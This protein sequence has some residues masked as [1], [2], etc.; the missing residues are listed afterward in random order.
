MSLC[1]FTGYC[2]CQLGPYWQKGHF[3][4]IVSMDPYCR[5]SLPS[6]HP[7]TTL[8]TISL[9]NPNPKPKSYPNLKL[10]NKEAPIHTTQYIRQLNE[11]ADLSVCAILTV[12]FMLFT[13]VT[14][15]RTDHISRTGPTYRSFLCK[16][17]W[18]SRSSHVVMKPLISNT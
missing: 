6:V 4:A 18:K 10:F 1:L 17:G 15:H 3:W 2:Y 5:T 16:K 8:L 13:G 9:T 11:C 7:Y 14:K 12:T